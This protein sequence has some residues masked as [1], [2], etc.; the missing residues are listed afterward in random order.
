MRSA[1]KNSKESKSGSGSGAAT[2][3]RKSQPS[4]K[5]SR[6]AD[7][8]SS[9]QSE[10]EGSCY[11]GKPRNR[12]IN[13]GHRARGSNLS[14]SSGSML[15]MSRGQSRNKQNPNYDPLHPMMPSV[16]PSQFV[17]PYAQQMSFWNRLRSYL[18]EMLEGVYYLFYDLLEGIYNLITKLFC[19][20]LSSN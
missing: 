17:H 5:Q 2:Q 16:D 3:K 9:S 8:L 7:E 6:N 18:F 4:F 19:G 10:N 15:G 14:V 1:K 13:R 11:D 12:V 20:C